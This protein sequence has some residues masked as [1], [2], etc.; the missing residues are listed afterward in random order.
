MSTRSPSPCGSS[1]RAAPP[2]VVNAKPSSPTPSSQSPLTRNAG[3]AEAKGP[4]A[5]TRK[6]L[7]KLP[8][9]ARIQKRPLMHPPVASAYS[10]TNTKRI[11][12]ISAKTPFIA[13]V[14]RVRKLLDP[15]H[16]TQALSG[17]KHREV[18][19]QAASKAIEKA[20]SLALHFQAQADYI[21]QI[22]TGSVGTVDDIIMPA[23]FES[24]HSEENSQ[25]GELEIPESRVRMASKVEIGISLR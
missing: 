3:A 7:P 12:Y 20:L 15:P 1:S 5:T 4:Q 6:T 16:T 17:G 22:R 25:N 21:V 11:I 13:A 9:G 10:S 8:K 23:V 18:L 14:K 19:L 2:A 24:G